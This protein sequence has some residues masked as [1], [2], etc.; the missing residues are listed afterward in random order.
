MN[1]SVDETE[2]L[3][4]GEVFASEGPR[5][6]R[7]VFAYSQDRAL[8]D[9]AVAEAFAQCLRRGDAVTDQRAWVWTAAFRIAAGELRARRRTGP[10]PDAAVHDAIDDEPGRLLKA[11][12]ELSVNQRAAVL[13]RGYAGYPSDEVAAML[14]ISR[15]T[16]RVHLARGRRRLRELLREEDD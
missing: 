5:L 15:A 1:E 2:R 9:D 14:G 8:T 3:G 10:M 4:L 11:I 7:A 13:L 6:W 12:G 16:V